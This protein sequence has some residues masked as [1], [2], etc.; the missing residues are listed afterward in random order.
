MTI[1]KQLTALVAIAVIGMF[2]VFGIGT[3][4]LD[5]VY[6]ETNFCNVNALPSI[7]VLDEAIQDTARM[8]VSLWKSIVEDDAQKVT[9]LD[10]KIKNA[11]KDLDEK[12]NKYEKELI[13]DDKDKELL[14]ADREGVAAYMSNYEKVMPLA[15]QNKD[16]E[17]AQIMI[18]NEDSVGKMSKAF[19]EHIKYNEE[20]S[21]KSAA[22][23][24]AHK[25]S[26]KALIIVLSLVTI[27]VMIFIGT[28]IGRSIVSGVNLI[29]DSIT[30]FVKTKELSFRI[31][32][33]KNNEI[34]E[35]ADSFNTLA[36]TLESTIN[37]AKHSSN[38]NAS[39]SSELSSTSSQI[40]KNAEISSTIVQKAVV[41]INTVKTFIE[42]T[43]R[44]SEVAKEDIK[45]AGDKLDGAKSKILSLKNEIEVASEAEMILSQ[46]LERMSDD[47][48]Q[49]KN[50]LTVISDIADQT[51]L[52]ALNAA[53]EA[54]RAG[55]HGRGFAVVADEVRKLAERTQKSL[56][57]INAS[58]SVIVQSI[59][60]SS[61]QMG[62]NAQNI[63]KLVGVSADVEDTMTQTNDA[64][65]H[66]IEAVNRGAENSI[67]IAGD[68]HKI[69]KLVEN[70][71]EITV[72][73]TRSVEEIASAAEHLY[74]LTEGLSQK[75]NQFK[76]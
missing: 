58:I 67:K 10:E 49:V 37:D 48:E 34:K 75:L 64:M 54:A 42:E 27:V 16:K 57:E 73:N 70:I 20:M 68:A 35:I 39:V 26:A 72:S 62:T 71:N 65:Q 4:K 13:A 28:S 41:E 2:A 11:K 7:I 44:I 33:E 6:E 36:A 66:G 40:G 12:L 59:M 15:K 21:T 50:I 55:E 8:R 14:K 3:L 51:N 30:T 1:S 74:E 24:H 31:K 18:A 56:A 22:D 60:D 32:Y 29:R 38:E 53:I 45:K 25:G 5:Q 63:K 52:L 76:S 46:K 9:E 43:A 61:E 47:A 19:R 69:I 17:A 23:A